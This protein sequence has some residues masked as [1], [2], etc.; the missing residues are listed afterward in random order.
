MD[1]YIDI[2]AIVAIGST[3]RTNVKAD[4]FSDLDLIIATENPTKWLNGKYPEKTGVV[5][6][7][8]NRGYEIMYNSGGF[9]ELIKQYVS[10]VHLNPEMSEEEYLNLVNDF[11]F[12]NIWAC[13]KLK[14]GEIWAAKIYT[15]KK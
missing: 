6:M 10:N 14:R 7:V 11:Y 8:M 4:E 1:K 3:T 2:K 5:Q 9:T 12:H 15:D 13:K